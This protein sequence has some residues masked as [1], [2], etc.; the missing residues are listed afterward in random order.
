[1]YVIDFQSS[2]MWPCDLKILHSLMKC[3]AVVDPW[4]VPMWEGQY[5]SHC[6]FYLIH[7]HHSYRRHLLLL[8]CFVRVFFFGGGAL[9]EHLMCTARWIIVSSVVHTFWNTTFVMLNCTKLCSPSYCHLYNK[10]LD[11]V[12]EPWLSHDIQNRICST[13][14]TL[15]LPL[16]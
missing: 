9:L 4:E 1:M 16:K 11:T 7:H 2:V 6:I 14:F 10:E 3:I 15:L 8:F 5:R 12:F 13:I